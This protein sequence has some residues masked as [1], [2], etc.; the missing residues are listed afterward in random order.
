MP[1]IKFKHNY[2][3]LRNPWGKRVKKAKLL[4]V[5][6]INLSEMKK[7]F[8]DYDT[9]GL[10]PLGDD[11]PFLCLLFQKWHNGVW[12]DVFT[13]V[14]RASVDKMAYYEQNVGQI[15]DVILTEGKK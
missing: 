5:F 13:T 1:E 15:F 8:R 9:D 2:K 6:P 4:H 11:G 14:R 3:K 10:Y 7:D 12:P